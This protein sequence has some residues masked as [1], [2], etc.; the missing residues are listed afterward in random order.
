MCEKALT[1]RLTD[2]LP[3]SKVVGEESSAADPAVLA[4]LSDDG[5]FWII[6]PIDGTRNFV[7]GDPRFAVM[8]ALVVDGVT[9]MGWIY[10]PIE[11]VCAIAEKGSGAFFGEK[12]LSLAR[13]R[14]PGPLRG[15]F[16]LSAFAGDHRA[17][18]KALMSD[19]VADQRVGSAAH[20]YLNI[21]KGDFD[22]VLYSKTRPWDHAPGVLMT[23]EAGGDTRFLDSSDPYA[24]RDWPDAGLLC[25]RDAAAWRETRD[26]FLGV[27]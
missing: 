9:Q 26:L 20:G 16:T 8:V 22:F 18:A 13:P 17:H 5:V 7:N 4:G 21:A 3:G 1:A 2:L 23:A 24:P 15:E 6:D 10:P 12:R 11:E 14:A 27:S 19:K 25:V